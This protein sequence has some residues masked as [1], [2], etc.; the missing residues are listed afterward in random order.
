MVIENQ[1]NPSPTKLKTIPDPAPHNFFYRQTTYAV[2]VTNKLAA[3]SATN[4]NTPQPPLVTVIIDFGSS[5]WEAFSG[6]VVPLLGNRSF[7]ESPV[8]VNGFKVNTQIMETKTYPVVVPFASA[9]Y[10]IWESAHQGRRWGLYG[11]CGLG[12][13]PSP[14]T[15]DL[16]AGISISY[17]SLVVS[18]LVNWSRDVRLTQG[19]YAGEL[20]G[21]SNPPTQTTQQYW[22]CVFGLAISIRASNLIASKS[23]NKSSGN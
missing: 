6:A 17:R 13:N 20:L 21:V 8:I 10:R 5:K 7:A 22:H 19:L 1:P 11:T 18:P 4:P 14:G 23:S 2:G 15:L 3:K 9:N 12:V 16:G